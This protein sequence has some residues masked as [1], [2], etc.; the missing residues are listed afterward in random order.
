[1]SGAPQ[2]ADKR[3][4]NYTLVLTHDGRYSHDMIDFG[5]MF[6]SEQES[7]AEESQNAH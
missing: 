1:M 4:S 3:R 5:R 2:A 7:K 6:E